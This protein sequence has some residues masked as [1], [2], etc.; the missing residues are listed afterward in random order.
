MTVVLEQVRRWSASG[1]DAVVVGLDTAA[2]RLGDLRDA[3][4]RGRP[5]DAW[6]GLAAD[7]ARAEHGRL[8][9]RVERLAAEV[10]VVRAGVVAAA[11]AVGGV[12]RGPR[13]G[14]GP[15]RRER[16]HDR[17]GRRRRR[18]EAAG[19][20]AAAVQAEVGD[21]LEQVLHAAAALDADLA[22]LLAWRTGRRVRRRP[23][24]AGRRGHVRRARD[25]RARTARRDARGQRRLV[26]RALPGRATAGRRRAP[27]VGRQ[28]RRHPGRRPGRGEQGPP[29]R[30]GRPARRRPP[31]GAGALRRPDGRGTGRGGGGVAR[32][33]QRPARPARR[34]ARAAGGA[35][36]RPDRCSRDRPQRP[37]A[38]PRPDPPA[39][40]GR[41]RRRR[42]RRTRRRAHPRVRHHRPGWS[43]RR[44]GD[45]GR[46]AGPVP[47]RPGRRRSRRRVRGRGGLAG[48]RRTGR[49]GRREH[50][51]RRPERW[52]GPGPLLRRDRRV[53]P[54][55]SAPHRARPLLR[56]P[57]HGL[58]PAAGARRRRRG[59]VRLT[60]ARDGPRRATC[61]CL[62]GTPASSRPRGTRSRISGGSATT[63]TGWTA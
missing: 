25:R 3:L 57:H 14:A 22:A 19:R 10:G 12:L 55:R 56:F 51:R 46:P 38:R 44:G 9:A 18:A 58:R 16:A 1:L 41:G 37:A 24:R 48:L 62:R 20:R 26:V 31:C 33:A 28:P 50:A 61:T 43:R 63:R 29:R 49:G 52:C 34:A 60:R 32:A 11:D 7:A 4:V 27:G 45:G 36:C 30:A 23:R 17:G 13:R 53:P 5:P 59:G 2:A 15:G 6:R 54:R 40:S 21:R 35:R 42:H 39:R 47:L 8:V